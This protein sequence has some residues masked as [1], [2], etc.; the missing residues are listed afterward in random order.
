MWSLGKKELTSCTK[1]HPP[2]RHVSGIPSHHTTEHTDFSRDSS[3]MFLDVVFDM[4]TISALLDTGSSINFMSLN[5]SES[6][7]KIYKHNVSSCNERNRF[8]QDNVL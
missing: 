8:I 1:S 3:F 4:C 2:E 7:S 6:I 5:L